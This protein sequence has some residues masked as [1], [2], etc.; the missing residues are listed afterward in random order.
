MF[1]AKTLEKILYMKDVKIDCSF[2]GSEAP[3]WLLKE[4]SKLPSSTFHHLCF[5]YLDC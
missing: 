1:R 4:D 5:I 3:K 2:L